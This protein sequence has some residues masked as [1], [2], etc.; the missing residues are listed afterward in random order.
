MGVHFEV[1]FGP[2]REALATFIERLVHSP[3]SVREVDRTAN[4]E[5][6]LAL[7]G[8]EADAVLANAALG[9][10]DISG[11]FEFDPSDI[12]SSS[13]FRILISLVVIAA[14]L[15]GTVAYFWLRS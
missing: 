1:A 6:S 11:F 13:S 15:A 10:Q 14:G 3:D 7:R 12:R 4:G 9:V 5:Y 8:P 2:S